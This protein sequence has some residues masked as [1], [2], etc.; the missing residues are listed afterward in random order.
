MKTQSLC[1]VSVVVLLFVGA[2]AVAQQSPP[3]P[4]P[5]GPGEHST[6]ST[7]NG[8][9]RDDE[10][11]KMIADAIAASGN[12]PSSVKV[13]VNSCYGGG[14]LGE[15]GNALG[16]ANFPPGGI[17]FIGAS[18]SDADQPAWGPGD[19]YASSTGSG[20][21]WS[22]GLAGAITGASPGQSVSGTIGTAAANDPTAPGGA[23]AGALPAGGQPEEPRMTSAN[24]GG[25]VTWSSG[26]EVVVFGGN[27]TN[28][29]HGNNI[30][31]MEDAFV[32][33]GYTGGTSNIWSTGGNPNGSGSKEDLQNLITGACSNIDPGEE[34]IL[35]ID[36]HGNTEFDFDEWWDWWLDQILGNDLIVVDPVN[37]WMSDVGGIR[38]MLHEGWEQGLSGNVRQGD[39][40]EPGLK[41]TVD[42]VPYP[43]FPAESF[44]DVF[45]DDFKL[46]LPNLFAG[47]EVF[48]PI[49]YIPALFAADQP[50]L[51]RFVPDDP[52]NPSNPFLPLLNLELTSGSINDLTLEIPEPASILLLLLGTILASARRR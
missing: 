31:N 11:A 14:M 20:S 37:G 19:S 2:R 29:R 1:V 43:D 32:N 44:F 4:S 24:G 34:L 12:T 18:A 47:E 36:D 22:N 35:Y 45:F 7:S 21:F 17:P 6:I 23:L 41:L 25:T 49:P 8:P 46:P 16:P 5:Q 39:M 52:S 9:V 51:L 42:V 33:M 48:L 38:P 26:A 30:H 13:F 15:I 50:H 27:N 28:V 40:V 10:L 3:P